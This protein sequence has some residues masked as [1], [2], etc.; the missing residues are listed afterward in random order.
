MLLE[1]I[2]TTDGHFVGQRIEPTDR[3]IILSRGDQTVYFMP[4]RT[5]DIGGGVTR[6]S[7]TSYI[8]DAKE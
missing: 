6:L 5:V 8:I 2:S 4:D 7:N 1:I 3:P